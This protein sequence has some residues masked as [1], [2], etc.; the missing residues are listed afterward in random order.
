M[1]DPTRHSL[2]VVLLSE[3]S[4]LRALTLDGEWVR[5]FAISTGELRFSVVFPSFNCFSVLQKFGHWGVRGGG[6]N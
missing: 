6:Q 5:F 4:A 3:K 2:N 1:R